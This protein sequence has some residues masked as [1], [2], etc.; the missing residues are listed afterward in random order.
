MFLSST[1]SICFYWVLTTYVFIDFIDYSQHV[2]I[3]NLQHVFIEYLQYKFWLSTHRIVFCGELKQVFIW[4]LPI[5]CY[6][7][8]F[9][10]WNSYK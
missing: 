2:L 8:Q 6:E 10:V 1:L 3:K 9:S 4:I 7:M 5:L